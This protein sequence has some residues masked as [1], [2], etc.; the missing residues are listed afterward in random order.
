MIP[1]N[2]FLFGVVGMCAAGQWLFLKLMSV[3][4]YEFTPAAY[5][6]FV[7]YVPALVQMEVRDRWSA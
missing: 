1:N 6:V 2:W 5:T 4:V 7:K 3:P